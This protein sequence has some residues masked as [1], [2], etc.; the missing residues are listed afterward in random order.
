MK[1][2]PGRHHRR[3]VRLPGYDY[4]EAGAYFVTIVVQDRA[5]AFGDVVNG[6]MQPNNTGEI[7][8]AEWLSL[9]ARFASIRLDAFIVMPNHL[10]GI[11]VLQDSPTP[12]LEQIV[13][14]FKAVATRQIHLST[15]QGFAWQRNYFEH[16]IRDE[17]SLERIGEY[18]INNPVQWELDRENPATPNAP[19]ASPQKRKAWEV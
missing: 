15:N 18:I 2:D 7:V 19:T 8:R 11:I 17:E 12:T 3:S 10:H 16:V 6:E 1:Y 13:R 4:S 14:A 9:P 5:C